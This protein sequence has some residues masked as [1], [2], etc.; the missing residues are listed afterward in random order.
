MSCLQPTAAAHWRARKGYIFQSAKR[1]FDGSVIH[2]IVTF[3]EFLFPPES[4]EAAATVAL[5]SKKFC[6][7][8]P[9]NQKDN[10]AGV[11][12]IVQSREIMIT[13]KKAILE[14]LILVEDAVLISF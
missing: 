9:I 6:K 1:P 5:L 4:E 14:K 2:S 11:P 10:K 8:Y 12:G 13:L 3:G 7:E